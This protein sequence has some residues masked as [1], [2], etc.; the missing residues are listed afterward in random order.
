MKNILVKVSGLEHLLG[1]AFVLS[2][3]TYTLL[4]G[5]SWLNAVQHGTGKMRQMC[6]VIN[7]T[8][9][10][11]CMSYVIQFTTVKLN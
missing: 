3:E 2:K 4:N 1:P 8:E 6:D 9:V 11:I 7:C 10:Q 5:S